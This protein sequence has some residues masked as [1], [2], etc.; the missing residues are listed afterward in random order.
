[1]GGFKLGVI[2]IVHNT[3]GLTFTGVFLTNMERWKSRDGL[4]EST[5]MVVF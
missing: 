1:M 4:I 5:W 3:C 2:N